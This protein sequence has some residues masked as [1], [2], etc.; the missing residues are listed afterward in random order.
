MSGRSYV[1]LVLDSCRFDTWVRAAPRVM[2]RLGPVQLRYSYATWTAP[3]HYNLLMGLL[4]HQSPRGVYASDVYKREFSTLRERLRLPDLSFLSMLPSVWLPSWLQAA[5]YDTQLYASMPVLNPATPLNTGF[6]TYELLDRHNDLGQV[7]GRLRFSA[8][9]PSF[10]V[11]NT[12]ETHYPYATPAEPE[13]E[14][15]RITGVH[16]VFRELDAELRAGGLVSAGS[17]F[18]LDRLAALHE[19]QVRALSWIDRQVEQLF[20]TCPRGTWVTITSDHG[21]L[22]GEDGY[23]GHGPVHHPKCVEVPLVEGLLR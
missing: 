6:D 15:P 8:D 23:F 20:D 10:I 3:S 5:G 11:I 2:A 16:G 9:R 21:E 18:D 1:L 12:G 7:L 22:F 13:S 17:V 14:W 4:P 19:R